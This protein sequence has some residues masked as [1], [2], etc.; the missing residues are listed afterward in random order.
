MR[1]GR[2]ERLV[3][4]RTEA[5]IGE[6]RLHRWS[7][8]ACFLC[9]RAACQANLNHTSIYRVGS[10][11]PRSWLP[12]T[13][14]RD[15]AG[16]LLHAAPDVSVALHGSSSD[17]GARKYV[18]GEST[19]MIPSA[20]LI[21]REYVLSVGH[22]TYTDPVATNDEQGKGR[23]GDTKSRLIVVDGVGDR[24]MFSRQISD[25]DNGC[26]LVIGS[27]TVHQESAAIYVGRTNHI[28]EKL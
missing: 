8:S 26:T 2:Y 7:G 11:L 24:E 13:R 6:M 15:L 10:S 28:W 12:H 25:P 9:W 18:V 5:H 21:H 23:R 1:S 20:G 14:T 27:Y 4:Q 22:H 19:R 3:R 16:S 17:R